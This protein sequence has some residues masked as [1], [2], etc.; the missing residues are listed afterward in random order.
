MS[1]PHEAHRPIDRAQ[2]AI[3]GGLTVAAAVVGWDAANLAGG[4]TYARVGPQAFP[5]AIAIGLVSLAAW[6]AIDA[7]RRATPERGA[8]EFVPVL[9]ILGGLVAQLALIGVAGFSIAT[10]VLFGATARA[11][12]RGPL[13][14]SI[15][16]GAAV[17]L[18]LWVLFAKGLELSLPAGPLERL[19]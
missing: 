13:Y 15:P 10:G 16:I 7:L 4:Q 6:T 2:F 9:W 1:S 5:Y 19:F 17:S 8:D 18:A 14:L 3:A 12:G 11:F